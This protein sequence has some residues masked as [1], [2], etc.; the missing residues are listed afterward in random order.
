MPLTERKAL[1]LHGKGVFGKVAN[2]ATLPN[3]TLHDGET[4]IALASQ[5]TAWLPGSLGGTYYPKGQY[6]SDG[7]NWIYDST[8]YQSSQSDVNTGIITDQFVSPSTL[9]NSIWAFTAAK[10]LATVLSGLSVVTGGVITSAD[11][12]LQ[13][14]GKL[15]Y[16]ISNLVVQFPYLTGDKL[17]YTD[18]VNKT[19]SEVTLGTGLS[20]T[21]G[22]LSATAV[23]NTT[24][25]IATNTNYAIVVG[26]GDINLSVTALA[27]GITF[28][29]SGT[30]TN[31][32]KLVVRIKDNGTAQLITFDPTYFE[33]KGMALPTTTIASKVITIGFIF[34][35]I[36]GK[37]GCVSVAQ[38]I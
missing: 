27:T 28:T 34:D 5:G 17:L 9:A 4:W 30:A 11:T 8:P 29:T 32:D 15:Q 35:S 22:T 2:Y 13:A 6:Y 23:G 16:Q 37:Y 33:A 19:V 1:A 12:I 38:E 20:F 3:P 7:T 14:F 24:F 36:T 25:T 10:G 21:S 31:F 26:T 18:L